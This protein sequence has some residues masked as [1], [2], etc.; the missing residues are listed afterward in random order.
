MIWDLGTQPGSKQLHVLT[1]QGNFHRLLRDRD[2]VIDNDRNVGY[3]FNGISVSEQCEE[4][5]DDSND[6]AEL[7]RGRQVGR[8]LRRSQRN[9][10][11]AASSPVADR[12]NT[13]R[14]AGIIALVVAEA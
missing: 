11:I 13:Q 1:A 7:Y 5:R 3:E 12:A 14:F 10:M 6:R 2:R 8:C 9:D 4:A